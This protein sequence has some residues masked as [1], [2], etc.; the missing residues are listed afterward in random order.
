MTEERM[1]SN[2]EARLKELR[3]KMSEK[4]RLEMAE[5]ISNEMKR[6]GITN[7][8]TDATPQ[9]RNDSKAAR[10]NTKGALSR[11]QVGELY[12]D[13]NGAVQSL[14]LR[15]IEAELA[16]KRGQVRNNDGLAAKLFGKRP[17]E[18]ARGYQPVRPTMAD[19]VPFTGDRA[20]V[21]EG[22]GNSF[23]KVMLIGG[24]A[25]FGFLKV[26]FTT[27]LVNASVPKIEE[28]LG[29]IASPEAPAGPGK[30]AETAVPV[31]RISASNEAIGQHEK[32]LLMELDTRRVELEQRKS[33]LDKREGDLKREA[34]VLTE[35][36]AE[37]RTL[38]S[39][40]NELRVE[41]DRKYQTRLEQLA[42]VYGAMGPNEAAVL[43]ARLDDD[44][45]LELLQRMP[46]K[47]MGQILS[48]M[49]KD[50]AVDL[51]KILTDEKSFR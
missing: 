24:I 44:T 40:L 36:M 20:M 30:T 25:T 33:G 31:V 51:T 4:Q 22:A 43:I 16:K 39:K 9:M 46:E 12:G 1:A 32:Q 7:D 5:I 21:R 8:S 50:R 10:S 17:K 27:G 41:R 34:Q 38:T 19:E 11:D 28:E 13:L 14:R 15:K 35:R 45:A 29:V 2:E 26:L 37:L 49:D 42:N 47:R 3:A 18:T 6:R 23:G 48:F